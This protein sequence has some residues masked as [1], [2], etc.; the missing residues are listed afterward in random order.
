MYERAVKGL[1]NLPVRHP[2]EI[3]GKFDKENSTENCIPI[4]PIQIKGY[5]SFAL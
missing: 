4:Y 1:N 5:S 2:K 3:K